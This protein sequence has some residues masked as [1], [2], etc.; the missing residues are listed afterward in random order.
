VKWKL[1]VIF[2]LAALA[3][4][5]AETPAAHN[6]ITGS[7]ISG[8]ILGGNTA[9]TITAS[10]FEFQ[11][12]TGRPTNC[13]NV[14]WPTTIAQPGMIRLWDSQVQWAKINVGPDRYKWDLLDAYLDAIAAHQPRDTMYTIG[15]TPCWD[16]KGEC[17]QG[18]GSSY[19]PDD[20][21]SEGSPSF[22]AFVL[23]MV[24]HCS[25]AG[26]CV[27]DTI[28]YWQLWNEAN[29][30]QRWAGSIDQLYRLMAPAVKTIRSKV[31]G[32]LILTPP[33]DR[34]DTDWM[35]DWMAE[36]N[37]LGRLSDIYAVHLYMQKKRPESRFDLIQRMVDLKNSTP[38]WSNTPWTDDETS[39][40]AGD[41]VCASTLD[42][43]LGQMVR[44]H[45][46][47]FGAGAQIVGWF[48]FNT[49]IGRDANYSA[50]Y[51]EMMQWLVGGHFTA[52]CSANGDVYTC[53]FIEASGQHALFV[54]NPNGDSSYVPTSRYADYRTL[55]GAKTQVSGKSVPVGVKPI[56]LEASN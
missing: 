21:T 17:R 47:H 32:A 15:Y 33:V 6:P 52:A 7:A 43:C 39:F 5:S 25:P 51:H 40:D 19:P 2:I 42:D 1:V 38:G 28:K 31:P 29:G 55:G 49:T 3:T 11:C 8:G 44:W 18:W 48:Y 10:S 41:Y 54:W 30:S 26:H 37:K 35:R 34:G 14:T 13:P 23:A 45:L 24:A 16:T 50:V 4:L 9:P 27:K 46:L 22:N 12:G 36:E 56:M 20:L 53:P